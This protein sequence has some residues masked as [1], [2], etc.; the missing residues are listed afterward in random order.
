VVCLSTVAVTALA[1]AARRGRSGGEGADGEVAALQAELHRMEAKVARQRALLASQARQ[2]QAGEMAA[3][4][5]ELPSAV[6][7]AAPEPTRPTPQEII[8]RIDQ[9]FYRQ[10]AQAAWGRAATSRAWSALRRLPLS[11]SIVE[12]V[13][14]RE[15]L[16]RIEATHDG[17]RAYD[18]FARAMIRGRRGDGLW[19][20]GLNSQV[21]RKSPSLVATVTF[22][23]REGAPVPGMDPS[24]GTDGR[25][26]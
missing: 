15:T 10:A 3:L 13:E 20:G 6:V 7:R 8:A 12:A 4:P 14:C 18:S 22:L 21:T 19:N 5:G 17:L 26:Q 24:G 1:L 2:G 16:C 23:A 25:Q 9:Q 11:G